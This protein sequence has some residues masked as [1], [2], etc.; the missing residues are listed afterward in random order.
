MSTGSLLSDVASLT[1]DRSRLRSRRALWIRESLI[2]GSLVACAAFSILITFTIIG[3]LFRETITFFRLDDV[4]LWGF[5][6]TTT[7]SPYY[8]HEYGIWP[9]ICGTLLVTAVGMT[10]ALPLGLVTAIYLSEYAPRRV[11][12]TLKPSLEI[13]AGIPTVVY[14]YFALTIITPGLKF[15]HEGFNVFNAFSAGIAV[16]VLCLPIVCSLAEDA[17]QAVPRSLRDAAYGLGGTRFDVS[18]KVVVPAALSG[19]VSAFLLA[20]ARAVGETMVVALAAGATPQMTADPRNEVQTMTGFIVQMIGGDVPHGTPEYY[21]LYAVAAVLFLIT[22]SI[23][24]IGN[25]IRK[26]FRE[27]YA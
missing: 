16:G 21:S 23:T 3:V 13:L 10:L 20:I 14:G 15:F 12:S 6:T 22:L 17:L 2:K 18:T 27:T 19:I 5:L 7:W 26:R 8:T 11:R 1:T 9:L 25:L 24:L 4:T